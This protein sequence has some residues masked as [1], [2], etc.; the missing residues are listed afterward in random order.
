[1]SSGLPVQPPIYCCRRYKKIVKIIHA[2]PSPFLTF[3][4]IT[5]PNES[6]WI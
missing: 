4:A 2:N 3:T 1:L 5:N 6:H